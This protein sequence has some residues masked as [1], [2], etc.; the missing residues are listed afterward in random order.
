MW[1]YVTVMLAIPAALYYANMMYISRARVQGRVLQTIHVEWKNGA[2]W[3]LFFST[4]LN[5]GGQSLNIS[6]FKLDIKRSDGT[7]AE[8]WASADLDLH[9]GPFLHNSLSE[10]CS[11]RSFDPGASVSG[12]LLFKTS[13][14]LDEL[15]KD[16][17]HVV[18]VDLRGREFWFPKTIWLPGPPGYFPG[19][20]ID[21]GK[22]EPGNW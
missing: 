8:Y 18:A 11:N 10:K 12:W 4:M 19:S 20:G 1:R 13:I 9:P 2:H 5:S 17:S 15:K 16:D 21:P 14:P 6:S 7:I 22:I 3:Y